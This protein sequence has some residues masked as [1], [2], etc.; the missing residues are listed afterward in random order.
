[1]QRSSARRICA[2]ISRRGVRGGNAH[3]PLFAYVPSPLSYH[4]LSLLTP[5]PVLHTPANTVRDIGIDNTIDITIA[6]INLIIFP[7]QIF[8]FILPH[9]KYSIR[10]NIRQDFYRFL[11]KLPF[12]TLLFTCVHSNWQKSMKIACGDGIFAL[13]LSLSYGQRGKRADL[14]E[15]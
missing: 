6:F 8:S 7:F 12:K 9:V 2:Q 3:Q 11:M 5:S 10:Y 14:P 15:Q 1:L 13:W 4:H